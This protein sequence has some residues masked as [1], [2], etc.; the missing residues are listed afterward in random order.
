MYAKYFKRILDF[1]LSLIA[2]IVLMPLM[3]VLTIIGAIV[4]KGNPFFTQLRP[5]KDERIFKLVKFRSMTCEKDADGKLLPDE[6]RLTKYGKFLRSTSLDELP[7]LWNILKGEMSIVGPRPLLVKYLP[8]YNDQQRHRHDV[9]PGLTGLAQVKGRNA[10]SWEDKFSLDVEYTKRISILSDL[11][12]I[13]GT[14]AAV[15]KK[16]GISSENSATM[17]EFTGTQIEE[18]VGY[19]L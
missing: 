15:L 2:L 7:E 17:E 10:I 18:E 5:G 3:I 8:L 19:E 4:M 16:D 9:R 6:Q 12:I 11:K 14:V 13:L 1:T